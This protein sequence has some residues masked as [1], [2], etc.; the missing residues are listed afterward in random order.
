[1][2]PVLCSVL[3]ARPSQ[4]EEEPLKEKSSEPQAEL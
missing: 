4:R 3:K 2:F 1:M